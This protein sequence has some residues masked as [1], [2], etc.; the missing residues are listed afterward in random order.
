M[1]VS[2]KLEFH[3]VKFGR[4]STKF[5][6]V[7]ASAGEIPNVT[8]AKSSKNLNFWWIRGLELISLIPISKIVQWFIQNETTLFYAFDHCITLDCF[9]TTFYIKFISTKHRSSYET[10]Q[11]LMMKILV[12]H[13]I[14]PLTDGDR[15]NADM[16]NHSKCYSNKN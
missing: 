15:L 10:L 7:L 13:N 2:E 9:W 12:C 1:G 14:G 6:E 16:D 8:E 3:A 4:I 5:S 11:F